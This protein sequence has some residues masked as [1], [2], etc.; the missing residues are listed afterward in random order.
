MR[1][2]WIAGTALAIALAASSGGIAL[3]QDATT[4]QL[5]QAGEISAEDEEF[6][7]KA[8]QAGVAEVRLGELALEKGQSDDV[9][10]F[11]QRMVQDH[12][13]AN[14][15]L[16]SLAETAGATPP[17]EMDEK[18]Q[19]MLEQLSQVSGEQ[20]DRL[21]MEGQVQDHQAAVALFSSEATQP[22]GPVDAL[23]GELL[24]A[25]RQHLDMAQ[26]ISD[27]MV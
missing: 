2:G 21:Y 1:K 8:I 14:Q 20:F 17:M 10:D 24:P 16:L 6:L 23:A 9:R 13:A 11:A 3:A 5:A 22:K 15:R 7:A 26:E 25:L 18:H 19:A 27:R 4:T 12:T